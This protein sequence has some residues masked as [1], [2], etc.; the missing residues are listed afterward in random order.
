MILQRHLRAE[1]ALVHNLDILDVINLD[2]FIQVFAQ[3]AKRIA[4]G[5]YSHTSLIVD[6]IVV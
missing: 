5:P 1:N 4:S 2:F 6:V 3:D